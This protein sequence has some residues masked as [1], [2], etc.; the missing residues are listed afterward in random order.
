MIQS[1]LREFFSQIPTP[2]DQQQRQNPS[3]LIAPPTHRMF[4]W[5]GAMHRLPE[6]WKWPEGITI[7]I[8]WQMWWLGVPVNGLFPFRHLEPSD[9]SDRN[10]RKRYS[11][12]KF[13]V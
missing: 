6:N 3:A 2:A 12:A 1:T 11:D 4:L 7:S 13:L 5:G 9:F 8:V 10:E